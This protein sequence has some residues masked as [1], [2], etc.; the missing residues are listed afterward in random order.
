M[1]NRS[2]LQE[3]EKASIAPPRLQTPNGADVIDV[4]ESLYK[5]RSRPKVEL[6][7]RPIPG[8]SSHGSEIDSRQNDKLDPKIVNKS[9]RNES[10][11]VPRLRTSR[12]L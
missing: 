8:L 1:H 10:S 4:V 12:Q 11:R 3:F 6:P 9:L 7:G 5:E 2:Q